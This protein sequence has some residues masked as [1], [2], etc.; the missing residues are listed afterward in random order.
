MSWPGPSI[1]RMLT[2]TLTLLSLAL[3]L[4]AH[5]LRHWEM[6]EPAAGSA[7]FCG[8]LI[9]AFMAWRRSRWPEG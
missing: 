5:P 1:S 7:L 8:L 4:A 3:L 2:Q 9:I 6:P